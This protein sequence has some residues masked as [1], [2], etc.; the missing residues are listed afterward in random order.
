[1]TETDAAVAASEPA[2][3]RG[4]PRPQAS[5]ARDA[6]VLELIQLQPRTTTEIADALKAEGVGDAT[7]GLAYLSIFRLKKGN[8]KPVKAKVD[9]KTV[10]SVA[11]T[12]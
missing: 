6:R 10:W 8:P 4:R 11:P 9:G 5:I 2:T 7:P 12:A 3:R 1:M